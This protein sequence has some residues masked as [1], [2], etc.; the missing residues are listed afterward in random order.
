MD[1]ATLH[2]LWNSIFVETN[3]FNFIVLVGILAVVFVKMD[4]KSILQTMQDKI[5]QNIKDV[6]QNKANS[7]NELKKS[8][9]IVKNLPQDIEKI[10]EDAKDSAKAISEKIMADAQKQVE[11][12]ELN[13]QKVI[14]A[15]EKQVVANIVKQISVASV[16]KSRENIERM[17]ENNAEMHEKYINESIDKLDEL[18]L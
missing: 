11:N 10:N 2:N 7:E 14:S 16:A 15:E 8:E 6:E 13:A 12:I 1:T 4:L 5:A 9:E 18:T 17:L 3:L